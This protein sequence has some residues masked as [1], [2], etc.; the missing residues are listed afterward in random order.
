[1]AVLL[2]LAGTALTVIILAMTPATATPMNTAI[3]HMEAVAVSVARTI[4]TLESHRRA[5][6]H[7]RSGTFRSRSAVCPTHDPL[8]GEEL[9]FSFARC[10]S[11]LD[12]HFSIVRA[13]NFCCRFHSSYQNKNFL[14][15]SKSAKGTWVSAPLA[16]CACC[17]RCECM[18]VKYLWCS[19]ALIIMAAVVVHL[20]K[21]TQR[22]C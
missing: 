11:D 21:S 17:V 15:S 13:A 22:C 9:F 20:A 18:F 3:L 7:R 10:D 8:V 12:V 16:W 14:L 19:V 2:L 1:M 6:V 5:S 4:A